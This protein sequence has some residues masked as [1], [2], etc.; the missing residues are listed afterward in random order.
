MLAWTDVGNAASPSV[1][2][3]PPG[4]PF[5]KVSEL[6]ALPDYIPGL[7][8]LYVDPA[9]LPAGPFLGYDH[10]R[11]LVNI[12]YMVPLADLTKAKAFTGLGTSV[13]GL[14]VDHTDVVYNPGHPGVPEPHYHITLWLVNAAAQKKM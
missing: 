1:T 3:S 14:R 2:K 4:G 10:Q 6:V 7:G 5:K 8:S 13:S 9:T 12:T 11:R